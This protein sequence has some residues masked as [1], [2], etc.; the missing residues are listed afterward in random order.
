[1]RFNRRPTGG[2]RFRISAPVFDQR[3]TETG[4]DTA[5]HRPAGPAG[6]RKF[7]RIA[8]TAGGRSQFSRESPVWLAAPPPRTKEATGDALK[9]VPAQAFVAQHLATFRDFPP[10]QKPGSFSLDQVLQK[11]QEGTNK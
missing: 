7:G 2:L 1:M 5:L 6:S 11:L 10:R 4:A 8:K 3:P 9:T